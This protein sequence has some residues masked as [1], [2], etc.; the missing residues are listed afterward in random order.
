MRSLCGLKSDIFTIQLRSGC[1][2]RGEIDISKLQTDS[3]DSEL[4]LDL[5]GPYPHRRAGEALGERIIKALSDG[6]V[7]VGAPLPTTEEMAARSGL[8]T[9]TINR[10][11]SELQKQ[12]WIE[13]RVG[14]GTF[15]GP[16]AVIPVAPSVSRAPRGRCLLRVSVLTDDLSQATSWFNRG[17]LEG[18]EDV[19]V[20][21]NLA[22]ELLAM[23]RDDPGGLRQRLAQSRPD[24]LVAVSPRSKMFYVLGDA[25]KMDIPAVIV[26]LP[27]PQFGLPNIHEDSVQG[28][29]LAVEHLVDHGH[30]RIGFVSEERAESYIFPRRR[31]WLRGMRQAGL[32]ADE[33]LV[34]WLDSAASRLERAEN[35]M[36]HIR[37]KDL[38]AVT[39]CTSDISS[40]LSPLVQEGLVRIPGD[41]SVVMFDQAPGPLESF[42]VAPTHIAQPL[43]EEGRAAARAV[44]RL[45]DGKQVKDHQVLPCRLVE[46]KSVRNPNEG[47]KE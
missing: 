47:M 38:T 21:E 12:G 10:T 2:S 15:V 9:A 3:K 32:P 46:G 25:R 35:L 24:A 13:R 40:T 8:S 34:H 7:P 28:I 27:A 30:E 18:L 22:I 20:E 36:Q 29:S 19:A 45:T 33:T 37:Q 39:L 17:I 5:S 14:Q 26:G 31:G 6:D 44:R 4:V 1:F 42:P 23:R 41:L 43:R 11:L 16:R